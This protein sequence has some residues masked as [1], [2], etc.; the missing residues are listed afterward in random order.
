MEILR[1]ILMGIFVLLCIVA[2]VLVLLQEGK[3]QGLGA[4]AGGSES[5]WGRNKGRSMEGNLEKW[6]KILMVVFF[7]LAIVLNL[8]IF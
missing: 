3:S 7:V 2:T 8:S 4:I 6:T 1:Y 5:Y